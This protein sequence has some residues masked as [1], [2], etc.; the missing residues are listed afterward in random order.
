MCV[1]GV[2]AVVQCG[3]G[4]F[5]LF[6]QQKEIINSH[7]GM[8]AAHNVVVLYDDVCVWFSSHTFIAHILCCRSWFQL[9]KFI[10]SKDQNE[11]E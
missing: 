6:L 1:C 7:G 2:R 3:R 10:K 4:D 8:H 11:D 5:F 9:K